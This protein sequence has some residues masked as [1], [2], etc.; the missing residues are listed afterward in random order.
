MTDVA[1]RT[2]VEVAGDLAA[3]VEGRLPEQNS[4]ILREFISVGE[5]PEVVHD[6]LN[7]AV[8][9]NF[10]LPADVLDEAGFWTQ[11]RQTTHPRSAPIV[12]DLL[13]RVPRAVSA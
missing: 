9:N 13:N 6:V 11:E 7:W 12:G 2:L 4:Q 5:W 1:M 3:A 8:A 10:P